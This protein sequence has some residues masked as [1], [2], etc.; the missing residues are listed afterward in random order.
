MCT[1]VHLEESVVRRVRS[2]THID[3]DLHMQHHM[4][5]QLH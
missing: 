5:Q 3:H 1:Y 4:L 2:H